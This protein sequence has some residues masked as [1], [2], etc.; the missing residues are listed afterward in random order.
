M[1][2]LGDVKNSV[3]VTGCPYCHTKMELRLFSLGIRAFAAKETFVCYIHLECPNYFNY[4][5]FGVP[6]PSDAW[7]AIEEKLSRVRNPEDYKELVLKNLEA[8][9]CLDARS[10][11]KDKGV[12]V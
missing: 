2:T 7:F 8:S 5:K 4:A 1:V 11:S 10:L 6:V 9:G 3:R 12:Y